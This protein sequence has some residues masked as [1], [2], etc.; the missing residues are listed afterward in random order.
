MRFRTSTL[1]INP[2]INPSEHASCPQPHHIPS[3]PCVSVRPATGAY[4][5]INAPSTQSTMMIC[6]HDT[7]VNVE[8]SS[9]PSSLSTLSHQPH[10]LPWSKKVYKEPPDLGANHPLAIALVEAVRHTGKHGC[11][12]WLWHRLRAIPY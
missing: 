1:Y 7:S 8:T 11:R 5:T 12:N 2:H 3:W 6:G 9:I 4:L 10:V